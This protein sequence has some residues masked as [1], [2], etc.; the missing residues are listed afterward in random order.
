MVKTQKNDTRKVL[1]TGGAGFIGSHLVDALV[2]E[3]H[4]VVVIDNLSTGK[5][6]QVNKRARFLKADIRNLKKI[7]PYFMGVDWVFHLAAKA[8]IQ[9]S[10]KD[11]ASTFDHNI[12]GTL[13]VLLAA[14]DAGIKRV[15]YSASSS[16]Y[17]DQDTLP[18]YEE[19]T[20]R[21]KSPY[22]LSKYVGEELCR[23]FSNLYG[24]E[25]ISLRYF[26][27]YGPRQLLSGAYA[28]V[29][30]IFLKQLKDGKP[31]TIV[32]DGSIQRDFT[33]VSDVVKANVLAAKSNKVGKG[34]VINIGT[35]KNY[36]INEVAAMILKKPETVAGPL[37]KAGL[38][39][40][41][42]IKP[43][44]ILTSAVKINKAVYIPSR[45]GETRRTL[46]NITKARE[47]L[48][49]KPIIS[50]EEGLAMLMG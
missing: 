22:S 28:T 24:L 46:A 26:N 33:H 38:T 9:P 39:A 23:L 27:V 10:I 43:E 19:M 3:G 48:G 29:V 21:F 4:P 37:F 1:V 2:Q 16:S 36:S 41:Q 31:L 8:R 34:E 49:W 15:I 6:A 32:G 12:I 30:G 17:G 14:R 5:K 13:N 7:K 40:G 11:P 25:T 44:I 18:L 35:G 45:P 20:P 50:L 47:L 42:D